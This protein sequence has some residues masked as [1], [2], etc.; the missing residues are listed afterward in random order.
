M[1]GLDDR[2]KGYEA[3]FQHR[4]ELAFRIRARRNRLIGLWAANRLG[5]NR[6]PAAEAYARRIVAMDVDVPGDDGIV[7]KLSSD[8][9]AKGVDTAEAEIRAELAHAAEEA[10]GQFGER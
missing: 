8:F 7:R 5:V 9:A 6:G 10:R 4:E 3:D 2:R 1:S